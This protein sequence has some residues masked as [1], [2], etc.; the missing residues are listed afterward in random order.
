MQGIALLKFNPDRIVCFGLLGRSPISIRHILVL[1]FIYSYVVV[2]IVYKRHCRFS[3]HCRKMCMDL[4]IN[5]YD[6]IAHMHTNASK[7]VHATHLSEYKCISVYRAYPCVVL[8]DYVKIFVA[9]HN[10][11]MV[12]AN[13]LKYG[14]DH[15]YTY[16][17]SL[18]LS[19]TNTHTHAICTTAW[20]NR[21][22]QN[23]K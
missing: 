23:D 10:N 13:H 14:L 7:Q 6:M 8:L 2:N 11:V 20:H 4:P 5:A 21:I 22:F 19:H 9:K 17:L 1:Y 16:T 15:T 12:M 3:L 18:S